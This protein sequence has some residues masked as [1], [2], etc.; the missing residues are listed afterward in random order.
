METTR[1]K[2]ARSRRAFMLGGLALGAGTMGVARLSPGAS[3]AFA[4]EERGDLTRVVEV[5][6]DHHL[7]VPLAPQLD[8]ACAD[9]FP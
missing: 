2:S 9:L 6:V 3:T 4:D 5:G 1:P 7:L 8:D